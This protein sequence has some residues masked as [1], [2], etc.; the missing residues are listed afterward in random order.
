LD[1]SN[2]TAAIV[3][4]I[5]APLEIALGN[6]IN[7]LGNTGGDLGGSAEEIVNSVCSMMAVS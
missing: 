7:L 6:A 1:S 3:A 2:A 4:N 5:T